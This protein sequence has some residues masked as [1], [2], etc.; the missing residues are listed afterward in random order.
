[1]EVGILGK[2][3]EVSPSWTP[4]VEKKGVVFVCI[5][6]SF[7]GILG[8]LLIHAARLPPLSCLGGFIPFSVRFE[9]SVIVYSIL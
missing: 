9:Y 7:H 8:F 3:V 1:M 5:V 2:T 6:L 4:P